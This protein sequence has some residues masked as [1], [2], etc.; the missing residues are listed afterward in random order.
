MDL[1]TPKHKAM[2]T[3]KKVHSVQTSQS[4]LLPLVY[5]RDTTN[6]AAGIDERKRH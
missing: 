3:A 2:M 1:A 5:V 6:I 4:L